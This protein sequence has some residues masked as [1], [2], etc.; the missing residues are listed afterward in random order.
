MEA[1]DLLVF[2]SRL[3]HCSTDNASD[4]IRAAMVYHYSPAGTVDH[5]PRGPA[6]VNDWVSVR[7]RP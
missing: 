4:E 1:G 3:M 2:H 7:R 6:Y 5:T